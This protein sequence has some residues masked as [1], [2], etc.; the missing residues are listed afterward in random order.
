MLMNAQ[1]SVLVTTYNEE[2]NLEDCLKSCK[3]WADEIIVVDSFSNDNTLNIAEKYG[4][5]I[6]Q[7]EYISPP[8]Q[9][10]WALNNIGFKNE[11]VFIIDADERLMPALRTELAEIILKDGDG[12]N[13]Y[14]VNRRYIFYGKWIKH[15]GW[16]P[17][18]N[19]RFFK[20]KLG[21]YEDR[22]IHEHVIIDGSVGYCNNDMLHEDRRDFRSWMA[23]QIRF[24]A[25]EANERYLTSNKTKHSSTFK[26][27]FYGDPVKKKRALKEKI[28]MRLPFKSTI[29][30][31]HLFILKKGFLDG[32][33]GLR[34]CLLWA[35]LEYVILTYYWEIQHFKPGAP[36]GG[37]NTHAFKKYYDNKSLRNSMTT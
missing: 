18:W 8:D 29:R 28:W 34:F 36:E 33:H 19:L 17:S 32:L 9:K 22:K 23:K 10:N 12:H 11:W 27:L 5:K 14:Y 21:R 37:V 7:H 20:H 2:I 30:F 26:D 24:A 35:I 31:V 13:G 4:A 3:G 15:C 16:Y 1:I 25:V 6:Y